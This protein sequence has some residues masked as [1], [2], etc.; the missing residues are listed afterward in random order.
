MRH[1]G[2]RQQPILIFRVPMLEKLAQ[3]KARVANQSFGLHHKRNDDSAHPPIAVTEWMDR[4]EL[5]VSDS[6]LRKSRVIAV[7][8]VALPYAHGVLDLAWRNGHVTRFI[9]IPVEAYPILVV[10]IE[11]RR[12]TASADSV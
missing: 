1:R 7:I 3:V 5:C 9:D 12:F 4:L 6:N 8:D 10:A 2:N 11:S